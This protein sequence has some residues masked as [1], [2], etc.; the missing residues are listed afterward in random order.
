VLDLREPHGAHVAEGVGVGQREA[1][2]HHVRPGPGGGGR[3]DREQE[4]N[5]NCQVDFTDKE[6]AFVDWWITLN[7]KQKVIILK[8]YLKN[9]N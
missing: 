7:I 8:L 4:Q 2:H 5:Q 6:C 9:L 1:Q 3:R